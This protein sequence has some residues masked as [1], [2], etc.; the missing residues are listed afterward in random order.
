MTIECRSVI[1]V[2][3]ERGCLEYTWSKNSRKFNRLHWKF[4]FLPPKVLVKPIQA[5]CTS[6]LFPFYAEK[7]SHSFIFA[8]PQAKCTL[9]SNLT[10]THSYMISEN[11][12]P[13]YSSF[14]RPPFILIMHFIAKLFESR[15]D[16]QDSRKWRSFSQKYSTN[17]LEYTDHKLQKM[18]CPVILIRKR[19]V[20]FIFG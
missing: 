18:T 1:S 10:C 17:C 12:K 9:K 4:P 13:D 20:V 3:L 6:S 7:A 16:R 8:N 19:Q 15:Q 5:A 11:P 14:K 2:T